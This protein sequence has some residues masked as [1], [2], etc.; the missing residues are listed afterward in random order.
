LVGVTKILITGM[1]GT[2]KSTLLN[3]LARRGHR[4][5][6]LDEGWS[7]EVPTSDGSGTEQLWREDRVAAL[8]SEDE[9][10]PLFVSGCASNQGTFYDRFDAVVL[11]SVPVGVLLHRLAT[12]ESN[13]F[14][15][16]SFERDRILR[17]LAEV[18]PRLR[19]TATA[20]VETTNPLD[21]VADIV[22]LMALAASG[23]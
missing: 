20:E 4:V 12:R 19:A 1:S 13:S 16:D 11:L 8:L 10:E 7:I 15:K 21:Q 17:D 5:V 2:G 9:A 18:E 14:G 6:D 22:Q 3:E 23:G